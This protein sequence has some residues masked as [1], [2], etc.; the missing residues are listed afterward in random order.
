VRSRW[1]RHPAGNT[2]QGGPRAAFFVRQ[3]PW[4]APE[5]AADG[6]L[7]VRERAAN[8]ARLL[9]C[10]KVD[11]ARG[12]PD[13]VVE[14]S[15]GSGGSRAARSRGGGRSAARAA[16]VSIGSDCSTLPILRFRMPIRVRELQLQLSAFS[17]LSP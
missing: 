11:G 17:K 9:T 5:G 14:G 16:L 1:C 7:L 4:S 15:L 10:G 12:L 8:V 13:G 2:H 6:A 3:S